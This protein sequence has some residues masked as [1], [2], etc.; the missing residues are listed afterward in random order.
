MTFG[1][2]IEVT[3]GSNLCLN[4]GRRRPLYHVSLD[5]LHNLEKD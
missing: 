2:G 1:K 5:L 4:T 3:V